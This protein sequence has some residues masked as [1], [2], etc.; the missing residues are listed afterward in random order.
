MHYKEGDVVGISIFFSIEVLSVHLAQGPLFLLN[1]SS[2]G[3]NLFKCTRFLGHKSDIHYK[4]GDLARIL[5][6]SSIET[7]LTRQ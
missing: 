5:V 7:L 2:E 6:S 3:G 4:E 1:T